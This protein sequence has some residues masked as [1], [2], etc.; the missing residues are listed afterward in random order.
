MFITF[1]IY[2]VLDNYCIFTTN[3]LGGEYYMLN[4]MKLPFLDLKNGWI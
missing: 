1:S 3:L 2:L 4:Y